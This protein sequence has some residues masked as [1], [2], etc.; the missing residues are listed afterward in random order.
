MKGAELGEFIHVSGARNQHNKGWDEAGTATTGNKNLSILLELS[1]PIR[2]ILNPNGTSQAA[3]SHQNKSPHIYTSQGRHLFQNLEK[4]FWSP[5]GTG[6]TSLHQIGRLNILKSQL[7]LQRFICAN[8]W[9]SFDSYSGVSLRD[10][11]WLIAQLSVGRKTGAGV[12]SFYG[13]LA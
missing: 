10:V 12:M 7:I 6:K 9:W 4:W 11:R 1:S 8:H 2:I 3:E 5:T 13:A